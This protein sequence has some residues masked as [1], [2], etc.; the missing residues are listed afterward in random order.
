LLTLSR[1]K[2]GA[3]RHYFAMRGGWGTHHDAEA[4]FTTA[5][6][7][8]KV[9]YKAFMPQMSAWTGYTGRQL[10]THL[11]TGI[12]KLIRRWWRKRLLGARWHRG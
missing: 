2:P 10:P 7:W 1:L 12:A 11:G 6:L 3:D 5:P 9:F 4:R 8:T